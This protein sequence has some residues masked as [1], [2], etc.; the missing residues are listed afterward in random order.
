[1]LWF[2]GGSASDDQP[3]AKVS[4][5]IYLGQS[6][7]PQHRKINTT[8]QYFLSSVEHYVIRL[9]WSFFLHSVISRAS[10]LNLN[11]KVLCSS[12]QSFTIFT[13]M[14][15]EDQGQFFL[16]ISLEKIKTSQ[17]RIS[18]FYQES[19]CKPSIFYS[20][21]Q[22][23]FIH[24]QFFLFRVYRITHF[25]KTKRLISIHEQCN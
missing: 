3:L 6:P 17:V 25:S 8:T 2:C 19:I 11:C 10:S 7:S 5:F 22:F 18:N 24:I 15:E 20:R 23:L 14:E 1:M 9:I 4:I 12:L 13:P 21:Y 16:T